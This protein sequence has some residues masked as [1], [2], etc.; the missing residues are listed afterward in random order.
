[1][2]RTLDQLIQR[3][4][5]NELTQ[6]ERHQL[7]SQLESVSDGWKQLACTYLEE[8]L[9]ASAVVDQELQTAV[10]LAGSHSDNRPERRHWFHHP[11]TSAALMACIAFLLGVLVRGVPQSGD[12]QQ[13]AASGGSVA[14]QTEPSLPMAS[15]AGGA[16][17]QREVPEGQVVSDGAAYRMRLEPDGGRARE[18]SVFDDQ[19]QFLSA[20]EEFQRAAG[21]MNQSAFDNDLHSEFRWVRISVGGRTVLIPVRNGDSLPE[22]N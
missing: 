1:M 7:L 18:L 9:L 2:T 16:S 4:V 22:F 10:R 14:S 19:D 6:T 12:A 20:L 21:Q 3:C 8:Q 17:T 5:D 13:I 11:L 15:S